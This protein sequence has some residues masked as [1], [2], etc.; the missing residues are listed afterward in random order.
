MYLQIKQVSQNENIVIIFYMIL[1]RAHFSFIHSV[2][3]NYIA[4]N[5]NEF[6]HKLKIFFPLK[7][8]YSKITN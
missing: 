4:L 1:S 3:K 6:I 2:I 7:I 5:I 8:K